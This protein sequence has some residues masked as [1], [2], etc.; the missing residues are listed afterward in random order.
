MDRPVRKGARRRLVSE[1]T[2][3]DSAA[4]DVRV[5]EGLWLLREFMC[6]ESMPAGVGMEHMRYRSPGQQKLGMV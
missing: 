3:V 1:R 4:D 6:G 5:H 2:G